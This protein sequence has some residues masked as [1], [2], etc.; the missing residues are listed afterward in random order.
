MLIKTYKISLEVEEVYQP[1]D[2]VEIY[3]ENDLSIVTKVAAF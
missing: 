1:G 3:P 2:I